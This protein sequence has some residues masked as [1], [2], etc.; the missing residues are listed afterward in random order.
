M[1][2]SNLHEKKNSESIDMVMGRLSMR[3]D[4][5]NNSNGI[6]KER[7]QKSNTYVNKFTQ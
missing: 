3:E 1:S 4:R 7:L 5:S 6:Y 2:M